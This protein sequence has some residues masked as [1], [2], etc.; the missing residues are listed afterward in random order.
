MSPNTGEVLELTLEQ[1]G[2]KPSA[3]LERDG[4]VPISNDVADLLRAG[5]EARNRSE[6]RQARQMGL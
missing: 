2:M 5:M 6:R 3:V 4:V 1:R